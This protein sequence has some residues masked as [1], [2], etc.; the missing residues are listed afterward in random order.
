MF[1]AYGTAFVRILTNDA[2]RI[3][4][5]N[6]LAT[7]FTFVKRKTAFAGN[8]DFLPLPAERTRNGRSVHSR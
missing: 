3:R 8:L 2:A 7:S 6:K 4:S 5:G 1:N